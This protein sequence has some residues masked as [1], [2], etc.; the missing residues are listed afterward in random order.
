MSANHKGDWSWY[1]KCVWNCLIF[2]V[3]GRPA[4]LYAREAWRQIEMNY[5][6]W[7]GTIM[8]NWE[9]IGWGI[10]FVANLLFVV[11]L[12]LSLAS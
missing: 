12:A 4:F 1:A 2:A 10:D 7:R 6:T 3:A 8:N 11:L 9:E 5:R